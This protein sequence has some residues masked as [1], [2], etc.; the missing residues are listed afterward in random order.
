MHRSARVSWPFRKAHGEGAPLHLIQ[1][2]NLVGKIE[3]ISCVERDGAVG[4]DASEVGVAASNPSEE[5]TVLLGARLESY[6]RAKR[7]A[8]TPPSKR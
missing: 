6:P 3:D 8:R 1:R 7:R 4:K 2:G 5:D